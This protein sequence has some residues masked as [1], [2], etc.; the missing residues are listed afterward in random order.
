MIGLAKEFELVYKPNES[1]PIVLPKNSQ[2]LFLLQRV[3]DEVHRFSVTFHR[4]VRGKNSL[5]S[6]LDG[7]SGIGPS[8]RTALLRTFG[9]V[10]RMSQ[11]TLDQIAAAPSMN[12]IAALAVYRALHESGDEEAAMQAPRDAGRQD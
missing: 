2:A 9:S 7:I 5:S 1:M 8:R 12:R 11:A 6:L 4:N 3:R 10:Q